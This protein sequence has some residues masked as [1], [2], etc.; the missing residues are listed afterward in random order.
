MV[1]IFLV[2]GFASLWLFC[3]ILF[4]LF[5]LFLI[6]CKLTKNFFQSMT[7][8][9]EVVDIFGQYHVELDLLS[10]FSEKFM[11][12]KSSYFYFKIYIHTHLNYHCQ[13]KKFLCSMKLI[14]CIIY[15]PNYCLHFRNVHI[16]TIKLIT[17]MLQELSC[18]E[19]GLD[20]AGR[21]QTNTW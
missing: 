15:F 21:H 6:S 12:Y 2:V 9:F 14:H 17:V 1:R 4:Y 8:N 10:P 16:I 20:E 3:L 11:W 18:L 5:V 7:C 19:W 13:F